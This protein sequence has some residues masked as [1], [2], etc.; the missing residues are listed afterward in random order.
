M[1]RGVALLATIALA[2]AAQSLAQPTPAAQEQ[3]AFLPATFRNHVAF[4]EGR[5]GGKGPYWFLIDT[6][7]SLSAFDRGVARELGLAAAGSSQVTGTAGTIE[8]E[9]VALPELTLGGLRFPGLRPT[10]YDLSGSLAPEGARIAGILGHDVLGKHAVLFDAAAGRIGFARSAAAFG[11]PADAARVGFRLDNNIPRLMATLDGV[12]V[13][14]RLDTGA[15]IA[16]GPTLFVNITEEVFAQLK[17]RRPGLEPLRYFTASGTGGTIR[18]PV[19]QGERFALGGREFARP[20][21]IVQPRTGYFA[22]PGA[23]G[24][25]G[26]YALQQTGGFIVDYPGSQLILLP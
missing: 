11:A 3:A 23:V 16:P 5:V 26:S 10:V 8:V 21:L 7:A 4:V 13:A 2:P 15:S 14:L 18:I 12:E 24:F 9:S 1:I 6:G 25:L 20:Q 22:Q 19:V 17:A